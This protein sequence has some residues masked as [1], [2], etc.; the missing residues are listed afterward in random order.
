MKKVY[1]KSLHFQEPSHSRTY[2]V[3][4]LHGP[5][6][7]EHCEL[8]ILQLCPKVSTVQT[9]LHYQQCFSNSQL[10][11]LIW[12]LLSYQKQVTGIFIHSLSR[13]HDKFLREGSDM[14]SCL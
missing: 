1:E 3:S 4:A 11:K 8:I 6:S 2:C 13:H 7:K 12:V 10:P 9:S 5:L 14:Y